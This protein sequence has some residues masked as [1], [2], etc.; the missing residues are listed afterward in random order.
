MLVSID[1]YLLSNKAG[2]HRHQKLIRLGSFYHP[3]WLQVIPP[4]LPAGGGSIRK[5]QIM[6]VRSISVSFI[7]LSI[8]YI[9]V[10]I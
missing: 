4:T 1:R 7:I 3:A 10:N 5:V 9:H 6:P 8:L 2:F